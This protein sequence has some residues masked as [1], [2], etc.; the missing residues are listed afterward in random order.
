MKISYVLPVWNAEHILALTLRSLFKQTHTDK[1]I[2]VIDDF[3]TDH[4]REIIE[5]Y[6]DSIDLILS[7]DERKGAAYCR[8]LGNSQA[9]GDIIAVCDCD[10]YMKNRGEI[11]EKFFTDTDFDVFYS[12]VK[13]VDSFD[14]SKEWI[15]DA[16]KW[17]F[18]SKC[19][20]SHPTVAYKRELALNHPYHE[21]SIETDLFEFM[22]LDMH[23]AG[24]TFGGAQDITMVKL[25]GDTERDRSVSKTLKKEMYDNYG[26]NLP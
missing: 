9:Q 3:S 11:L 20:I 18:N 24:A 2:I 22:L 8:N 10:S 19:P 16:I 7:N 17:D 13:C 21:K 1:E 15:Q 6:S 25:E 5:H 12:S 23:K 4:T 26:I 14:P